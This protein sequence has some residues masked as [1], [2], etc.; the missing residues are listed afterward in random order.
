MVREWKVRPQNA[1]LAKELSGAL[2]LHPLVARVLVS[3]GVKE[4][5]QARKFLQPKL[6]DL[7]VPD[8]MADREVAAKR[9]ADA[10]RRNERIA[11]FGDYDVDGLTSA[12]LLSSTLKAMGA[13]V[14]T[15]VASRFDGGYGFSEQALTKVLESNPTLVVTC[16]CG[17]SDHPRLA[18][19]AKRGIDAI[20]VDHHKVPD[21]KLPAI[22]FLNPHRPECGFAYKGLASVGLALSLSAAVR[23][24]LGISLDLREYLELVA[25]GTIADVA[26]LTGDNRIL[27]RAGLE[28][29]SLGKARPGVLALMKQAKIRGPMKAFDVGFSLGPML[30]APGR[31]G[32]ADPTLRLLMAQ[33]PEE[34]EKLAKMLALQNEERREISQRI[35]EEAIAQV[36]KVYG[37]E[38]QSGIVVAKDGWH[39]GISGIVAGRL[40]DR[41]AVPTVVIA[42]D[43]EEGVGSARAPKG[44]PLYQLMTQCAGQLIRYGGHD[45]A[46]GMSVQRSKL[47]AFRDEFAQACQ[48][49]RASMGGT[50]ANESVEIDTEFTA[51]DLELPLVRALADLEPTGQ[52]CAESQVVVHDARV[53]SMRTV[54]TNH[55][56]ARIRMGSESVV[57]FARDGVGRVS[58]GELNLVEGKRCSIVGKLRADSYAGP[59]AVQLDVTDTRG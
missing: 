15:M 8:Q 33:K 41:F 18:K 50:M 40:V 2:R 17:T 16:D 42:V 46:A 27:T 9:L 56:R 1:A 51:A 31:L 23:A 47:R 53:E 28:R 48:S 49:Y 11:V 29:L 14:S 38:L 37:K 55:L 26:P 25:M 21:E 6:A 43:G 4:V 32:S 19:L 7:T 54:G 30:N 3:R 45:G 52:D 12:A 44:W 35:S 58:R 13:T 57:L 39:H 20:V 24:E 34:G 10:I 59:E 36:Q 5:G 22:A